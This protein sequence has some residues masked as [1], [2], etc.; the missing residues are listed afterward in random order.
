[1]GAVNWK[2]VSKTLAENGRVKLLDEP[3]CAV[4]AKDMRVG[5]QIICEG[6]RI[7]QQE[8]KLMAI[9]IDN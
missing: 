8:T 2:T 6:E 9:K 1:V 5:G 3:G 4:A 7:D